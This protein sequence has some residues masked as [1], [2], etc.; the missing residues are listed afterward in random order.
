MRI[1]DRLPPVVGPRANQGNIDSW[2]DLYVD[3][4]STDISTEPRP[5]PLIR[6]KIRIFPILLPD[7]F[8]N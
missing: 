2:I 6:D 5:T 8:Y 1:S 7:G 4:H 3:R